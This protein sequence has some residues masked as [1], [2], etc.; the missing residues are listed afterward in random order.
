MSVLFE[1][2]P[3]ELIADILGELDIA[4]LIKVSYLSRRLHTIA[5]D[6]SLNPWRRPIL[7]NLCVPPEESYEP[8]L[9]HLSVR[10]TVPRH[11][12]LEVLSVAKAG[13]I[14]FEATLPNLRESEWEECFKRRFLPGWER[15]KKD[16]TWKEAFLRILNRVWH[17]SHSTCT[18]DEAWTK[19]IML[20]RNGSANELE[21]SSRAYNPML[22]FNEFK[23]QNNL[24]HLETHI[25]LL[26]EFADVRIIAL[27]V[28]NRPRSTFTVNRNARILLHPPGIQKDAG[29]S[30]SDEW[31]SVH[32]TSSSDEQP[33]APE[34]PTPIIGDINQVYR[35]LTHPL[36]APSHAN[37]PFFTPGGSDKRWF[38]SGES[39]ENGR[40]WVGG[41]MLTAQL[42][43]PKSKESFNDGPTLQDMDLVIGPG[44]SQF[45]SLTWAD[46]AAVAPWLELTKRIDGPGLGN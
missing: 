28:L 34:P 14:L 27:G 38:G 13:W 46:L 16:G 8:A 11:N 19:Y 25:R 36:P 5:S 20:N 42:I 10:H 29:D 22:V 35:R 33:A 45:A 3:V 9:K 37:Y 15:W 41:L 24:G 4:S 30:D 17:R 7:R 44:R 23:L 39:E 18:A 1:A 26:V 6:S 32:S 43:S 31:R 12:W 40:Q 2:L 21:A